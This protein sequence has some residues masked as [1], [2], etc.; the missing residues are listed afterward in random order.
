M[1]ARPYTTWMVPRSCV[2][3]ATLPNVRTTHAVAV[4]ASV[5][6]SVRVSWLAES[7][8]ARARRVVGLEDVCGEFADPFHRENGDADAPAEATGPAADARAQT[9]GEL[10]FKGKFPRRA[11][12]GL[13]STLATSGRVGVGTTK[14]KLSSAP[15]NVTSRTKCSFEVFASYTMRACSYASDARRVTEREKNPPHASAA[16]TGWKPRTSRRAS[17][18]WQVHDRAMLESSHDGLRAQPRSDRLR[19]RCVPGRHEGL[20]PHRRAPPLGRCLPPR[21]HR[22]VCAATRAVHVGGVFGG[23]C[24]A[25]HVG[26]LPGELPC[27]TNVP[28]LDQRGRQPGSRLRDCVR[29]QAVLPDRPGLR[30][31]RRRSAGGLPRQVML[32]ARG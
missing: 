10:V 25:R 9:E 7:H 11:P 27:G 13:S 23:G 19:G 2:G 24:A 12:K 3:K 31:L 20:L 21:I 5:E 4:G 8:V 26:G 1:S 28:H 29:H 18:R 17:A 32:V 15:S 22:Q 16:G 6:P 14:P 30:G